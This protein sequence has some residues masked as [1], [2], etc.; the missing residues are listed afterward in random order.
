MGAS[1][2]SVTPRRKND[3]VRALGFFLLS[4][5]N[6]YTLFWYTLVEEPA[7]YNIKVTIFYTELSPPL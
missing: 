6:N 1:H 4:L 3:R 5:S 2:G 7:Q